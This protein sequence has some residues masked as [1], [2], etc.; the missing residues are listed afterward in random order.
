MYVCHHSG[1]KKKG[2]GETLQMASEA[3]PEL[4]EAVEVRMRAVS[5]VPVVCDYAVRRCV[6][7]P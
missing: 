5:E 3:T 7:M 2:Q 1:A 6:T 4:K